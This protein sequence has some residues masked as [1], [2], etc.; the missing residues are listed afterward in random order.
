MNQAPRRLEL[1][2]TETVLMT[3]DATATEILK[4][5]AK[6]GVQIALDDFGV[7]YSS[8]GYLKSFSFDK[9]KIDRSFMQDI[10][11]PKETAIFRAITDLSTSLGV[12]TVAEG[13]ETAFQIERAREQGCTELQGYFFGKPGP[14]EQWVKSIDTEQKRA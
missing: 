9:I 12:P 13:V 11:N 5:L 10:E 2:I 3:Q 6:L 7:G 1:E 14:I 8:L 4:Q